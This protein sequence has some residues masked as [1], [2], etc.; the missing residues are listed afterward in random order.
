MCRRPPR[1]AAGASPARLGGTCH[2]CP[3]RLPEHTPRFAEAQELHRSPPGPDGAPAVGARTDA[4]KPAANRPACGGRRPGNHPQAFPPVGR[5]S[6]SPRYPL[7]PND[8]LRRSYRSRHNASKS[9]TFRSSRERLLVVT[10]R[11][12]SVHPEIAL[13][14]PT[15]SIPFSSTNHSGFFP[16]KASAK[17]FGEQTFCSTFRCLAP[18]PAPVSTASV[19]PSWLLSELHRPPHERLRRGSCD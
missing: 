19:S 9:L 13:R 18:A 11:S 8:L 1:Q 12:S 3:R 17:R 4:L 10:I 5:S 6:S 16:C 7:A 2:V 15:G 14:R